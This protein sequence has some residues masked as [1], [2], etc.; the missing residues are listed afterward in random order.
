MKPTPIRIEILRNY[1]VP[2]VRLQLPKGYR[3]DCTLL[4]CGTNW[5]KVGL[6]DGW[7]N[8]TDQRRIVTFLDFEARIINDIPSIPVCI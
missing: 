1:Q 2:G 3:Y 7:L 8:G 5:I 6:P 4:E